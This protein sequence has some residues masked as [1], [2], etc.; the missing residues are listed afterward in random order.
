MLEIMLK[1]CLNNF[2][3]MCQIDT[4]EIGI[5][6]SL[7]TLVWTIA[8][9]SAKFLPASEDKSK[10]KEDFLLSDLPIIAS[11]PAEQDEMQDLSGQCTYFHNV[12]NPVY[13]KKRNVLY[14]IREIH[15][16]E[17]SKGGFVDLKISIA[18]GAES[19]ETLLQ[20]QDAEAKNMLIILMLRKI[21]HYCNSKD[22]CCRSR[23]L[24]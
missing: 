15:V 21:S 11:G 6:S 16:T 3:S 19:R 7:E 17:S 8:Q 14:R 1:E 13:Q 22:K 18:T 24:H 4:S 2:K 20:N 9:A 23:I 5:E 10:K 12:I